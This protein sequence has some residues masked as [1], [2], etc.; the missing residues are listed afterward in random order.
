MV[1]LVIGKREDKATIPGAG[2]TG[3]AIAS[4][5]HGDRLFAANF[6][7]GR[8]DVFDSAFHQVKTAH[9][10]FRDPRLPR[11]YL[12]FN[13]QALNGQTFLPHT[14]PNPLPHRPPAP[15]G[16]RP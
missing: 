14:K 1:D 15:P 8:V 13:S 3:L 10:Q 16:P 5:R 12:P 4:T 6:A 9:W 11:G 2:S 7:Q